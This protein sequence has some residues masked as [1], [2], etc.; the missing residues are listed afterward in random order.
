MAD[1]NPVA[2]LA[3]LNGT[4]ER[5]QLQSWLNFIAAELHK[6]YGPWLSHAE[7]GSAVQQI[8]QDKIA[9]RLAMVESLLAEQGPFLMG[10]QF[11]IADAYLF[12]IVGW[13]NFAKINLAPFP[14][15][16]FDCAFG[17]KSPAGDFLSALP[18][19]RAHQWMFV[20]DPPGALYAS[21]PI[22]DC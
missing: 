10:D 5:Y 13:S 3:P 7:Y 21:S 16:L 14:A 22:P 20:P 18:R 1:L 4:K 15:G 17:V 8:A 19:G 9:G 2:R 12:V 6:M 11:T